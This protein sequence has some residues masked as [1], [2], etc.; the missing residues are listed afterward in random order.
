MRH[1]LQHK[2]KLMLKEKQDLKKKSNLL[3]FMKI[4]LPR[5]ELDLN[6]NSEMSGV[7]GLWVFQW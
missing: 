4:K 5:K 6:N 7:L 3:K 1:K 2:L